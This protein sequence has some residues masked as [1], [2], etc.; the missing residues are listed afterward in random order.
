MSVTQT[1][2][3]NFPCLGQTH[4]MLREE[5]QCVCVCVCLYVE[6]IG[7]DLESSICMLLKHHI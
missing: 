3:L 4:F 1:P 2:A 5:S 6:R 7:S